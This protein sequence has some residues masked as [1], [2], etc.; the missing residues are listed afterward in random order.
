MNILDR[1]KMINLFGL[2]L[3]SIKVIILKIYYFLSS[4]YF[5]EFPLM[6][7]KIFQLFHCHQ[8]AL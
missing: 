2:T 4:L 7:V 8:I 5:K 6:F 1:V 3:K